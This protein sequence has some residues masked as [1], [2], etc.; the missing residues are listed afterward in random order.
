MRPNLDSRSLDYTELVRLCRMSMSYL[1]CKP[2][3]CQRTYWVSLWWHHHLHRTIQMCNPESHLAACKTCRSR[4]RCSLWP[5]Q[6][7]LSPCRTC[8]VG[9]SCECCRC[10]RCQTC[11]LA[12]HRQC[13]DSHRRKPRRRLASSSPDA[14]L[15]GSCKV[16]RSPSGKP[17]HSYMAD[18]HPMWPSQSSSSPHGT[19]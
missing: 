3:H 11:K 19:H 6:T 1:D 15:E 13:S 14:A 5:H 8:L 17:S 16:S 10:S 9:S 2:H 12:R 18:R 4:N 7:C